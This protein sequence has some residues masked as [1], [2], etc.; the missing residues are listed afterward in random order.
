MRP[1]FPPTPDLT[2]RWAQTYERE[3]VYLFDKDLALAK[4][5]DQARREAAKD[6]LKIHKTVAL[7]F[8]VL[9]KLAGDDAF[10]L[11]GNI[12]DLEKQIKQ[13]KLT[14]IEANHVEA[15]ADTAE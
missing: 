9:G 11:D 8:A 6:L 14:G 7:Y 10:S 4:S 15:Y 13:S 1:G 5:E 2:Q 3:K 12:D